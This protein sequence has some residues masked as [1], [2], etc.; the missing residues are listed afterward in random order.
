MEN[1]IGPRESQTQASPSR[2]SI[3][4]TFGKQVRKTILNDVSD[5]DAKKP[6][7][8]D[9]D[10]SQIKNIK[11]NASVAFIRP[12]NGIEPAVLQRLNLA[13]SEERR[14]NLNYV[15]APDHYAYEKTSPSFN[16]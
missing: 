2:K 4:A 9:Y 1:S 16:S 3:N 13:S 14:L 15:P 10:A 5:L 6:G 11:K 8:A 7:P 12:T